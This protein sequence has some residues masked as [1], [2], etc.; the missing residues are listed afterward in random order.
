MSCY[1]LGIVCIAG[2]GTIKLVM[3]NLIS[4]TNRCP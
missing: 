4:Q 3:V 1:E 2:V